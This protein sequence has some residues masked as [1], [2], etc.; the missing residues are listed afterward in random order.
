[1][2]GNAEVIGKSKAK[3]VRVNLDCLKAEHNYPARRVG[4]F[5]DLNEDD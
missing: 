2:R 4:F 3:G 1:M 5:L